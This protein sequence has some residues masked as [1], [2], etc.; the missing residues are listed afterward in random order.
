MQTKAWNLVAEKVEFNLE[1]N[2][3]YFKK[4]VK[5]TIPILDYG[6]G[7]GRTCQILSRAGYTDITGI[8]SSTEMIKRGMKEK[9]NSCLQ[10]NDTVKTNF[11]DNHFGA[12]I[13]CAVLTCVPDIKT[14][15]QILA[16]IYRIL[17]PDGILH[18]VEFC[19]EKGK[20]FESNFGVA[21]HHQQPKELLTLVH[22]FSE[23][24]CNIIQTQTMSGKDINAFSYFGQKL[25]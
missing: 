13:L 10:K 5:T 15:E 23:I 12:I 2:I 25:I 9:P 22:Y 16:E 14:K 20:Y 11:P 6:C 8:D 24:D 18:L 17:K 21:M 3:S 7:Y 4:L 1:I 19:N